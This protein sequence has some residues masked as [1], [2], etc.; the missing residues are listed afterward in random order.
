MATNEVLCRYCGDEMFEVEG[1]PRLH[2][3]D[4]PYCSQRPEDNPHVAVQ[5]DDIQRED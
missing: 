4:G 2:T 1:D 3:T 5:D